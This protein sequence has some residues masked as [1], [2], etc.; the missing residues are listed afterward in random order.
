MC[1]TTPPEEWQ[2]IGVAQWKGELYVLESCEHCNDYRAARLEPDDIPIVEH[3][4]STVS[5]S[6]D[7][8]KTTPAERTDAESTSQSEQNQDQD[9]DD[10]L[11]E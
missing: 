3:R 5:G 4:S 10:W 11:I 8:T 9:G 1:T 6:S 2:G 7:V